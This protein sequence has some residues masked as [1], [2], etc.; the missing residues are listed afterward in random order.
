MHSTLKDRLASPFAVPTMVLAAEKSRREYLWGAAKKVALTP[1]KHTLEDQLTIVGNNPLRDHPLI[2][3][4]MNQLDRSNECGMTFIE[5]RDGMTVEAHYT[6]NEM[7]RNGG[8]N[9]EDHTLEPL[10][11]SEEIIVCKLIL[12]RL[13]M[14]L[15][16]QSVWQWNQSK[17]GVESTRQ[18][19][20]EELCRLGNAKLAQAAENAEIRV[21][22]NDW[23]DEHFQAYPRPYV[24]PFLRDGSQ[25]VGAA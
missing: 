4:A 17:I 1:R 25:S 10:S 15:R 12:R 14:R 23:I 24:S 2:H 7:L 5:H 22:C 13:A 8:Y 9:Q 18:R 11:P 16:V 6:R 19:M 20:R 21:A 3:R